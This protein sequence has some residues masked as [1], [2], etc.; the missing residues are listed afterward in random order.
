MRFGSYS[1][2]FFRMAV[3]ILFITT[4]ARTAPARADCDWPPLNAVEQ[5]ESY[6]V[7]VSDYV[8]TTGY[9]SYWVAAYRISALHCAESINWGPRQWSAIIG[10]GGD[11]PIG[12]RSAA[13]DSSAAAPAPS[14]HTASG[15][16]ARPEYAARPQSPLPPLPALPSL[17][18]VPRGLPPLAALPP[19]RLPPLEPLRPLPP[20]PQ[21]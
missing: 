5:R 15:R 12:P 8:F 20:L 10:L 16:A 21:P 13:S 2:V 14:G 4:V 9:Y 7:R 17:P 18:V 11:E 6:P 19:E 3:F 1:C